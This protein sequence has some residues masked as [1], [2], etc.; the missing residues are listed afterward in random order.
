MYKTHCSHCEDCW[1]VPKLA[2]SVIRVSSH[3]F[4]SF[5]SIITSYCILLPLWAVGLWIYRSAVLTSYLSSTG[6][7]THTN[8]PRGTWKTSAPVVSESPGG[9]LGDFHERSCW[10]VL[11]PWRSLKVPQSLHLCQVPVLPVDRGHQA[12]P[13]ITKTKRKSGF[14]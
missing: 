3:R 7:T 14:V 6:G 12:R 11:T 2:G 1:V 10:L 4:P 5:G 13:P 9:R 8:P